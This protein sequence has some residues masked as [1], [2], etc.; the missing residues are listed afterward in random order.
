MKPP[1][2]DGRLRNFDHEQ[3]IR[4]NRPEAAR[5]AVTGGTADDAR[6]NGWDLT[7]FCPEDEFLVMLRQSRNERPVPDPRVLSRNGEAC[8]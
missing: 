4:T 7:G 2:T 8:P 5:M 3:G 6:C 1:P